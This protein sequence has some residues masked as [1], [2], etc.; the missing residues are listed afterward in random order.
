MQNA[1][2]S[3][4]QDAQKFLSYWWLLLLKKM[5]SGGPRW[6]WSEAEIEEEQ[7]NFSA[8]MRR[9]ITTQGMRIWE[10]MQVRLEKQR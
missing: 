1:W 3:I 9:G 2:T 10:D 7:H 6:Q 4:S 8:D 5:P